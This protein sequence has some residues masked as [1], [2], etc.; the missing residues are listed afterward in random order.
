M[1]L[2]YQNFGIRRKGSNIANRE[3][4]GIRI[5]LKMN[6]SSV[7][8]GKLFFKDD[9]ALFEFNVNGCWEI[10]NALSWRTG[11]VQTRLAA[12]RM[13]T[14]LCYCSLQLD[15]VVIMY[16]DIT[17]L[18]VSPF[19]FATLAHHSLPAVA[20]TLNFKR[21]LS[22]STWCLWRVFSSSRVIR[23]MSLWKGNI[24]PIK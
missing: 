14:M 7:Q 16:Y 24:H 20:K 4:F 17:K 5:S 22:E 2:N 1:H 15:A 11:R 18:C 13:V 3:L 23:S 8:I 21:C 6:K 10:V 9:L 12:Q 19:I